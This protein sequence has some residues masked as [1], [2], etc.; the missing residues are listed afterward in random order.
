[1]SGVSVC[2]VPSLEWRFG[3]TESKK[4]SQSS[5]AMIYPVRLTGIHDI[6]C[7]ELRTDLDDGKRKSMQLT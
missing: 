5:V 2:S 6:L 4:S 7:F 3:P 1:M